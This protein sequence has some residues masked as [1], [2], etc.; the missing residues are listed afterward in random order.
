MHKVL[1]LIGGL[2]I[3]MA[4]VA[5]SDTNAVVPPPNLPTITLSESEFEGTSSSNEISSLLQSSRDIFVSTAGFNFG[6]FRYRMRGLDSENTHVL[7]N[8]VMMNDQ[9][10][11]RASYSSWGGLNDAMRNTEVN[12]MVEASDWAFGGIGGVTNILTRAGSYR[13]TT[14]LSYA[15]SNRS[16]NNRIMFL[17]STGMQDNGWAVT[18]SGSR[19]WSQEGYVPGTFYD[20]WSYFAS[21]EKKINN[22]HSFG[23]IAF[24]AP[25]K[26]A[27]SGVSVQEAY[28]L[29]GDNYYN[30][31]WGYQNG[32]VRNARVSNNNQPMFQ[33]S[34]YWTPSDKT[35]VQSTA[36]Y[37]FG[38]G[39]ATALDWTEANDP[40][41]DYYRNLP[42][43][44][45]SIG[46]F[47]NYEKYTNLWKNDEH[48]RQIKWDHFYF[49]NS[50]Q[51]TT[52]MNANGSGNPYT[53][54]KSKFVIEDRRMDK[55]Q[56]GLNINVQH[57]LNATAR[58]VGGL[59]AV[60][61]KTRHHKRMVDLLGGDFWLDIDKY[62]DQESMTIT[63]ASQ[64]DLRN[65]NHIIK[66]G[67][68]YGYDYLANVNNARLWSQFEYKFMKMEVYAAA[69]L[70][71]TQFWRTGKMQNGR[72]PNNSY[73]DG[74]K[75]NFLNGGA[76]AGIT[77]AIDGRNYVVANGAYLHRAP[78]FRDSYISPR[79]RD[80]AVEGLTSEKVLA[81]DISY[82]LRS[83]NLK[84]RLT[85]YHT[86]VHDGL[87]VRSY[88]HEDL[89]NFINYIMED[90]DQKTQGVELG[91]EANL[92][93]TLSAHAV[94]GKS[95]NIYTNRPVVT[96]SADNDAK[97]LAENRL[98]YLKNYYVG[99]APQTIASA[100]LRY[101]AP[102]YWFAGITA[103]YF[104]DA[105]LEPNPDNH[106]EEILS[107]YKEGDVR[108]DM[109]LDQPKL[110]PGFTLDF[111][112]GKSWMIKGHYVAINL[113]INNLLNNK[114][115]VIWGFEQLRTDLNDPN[116]FPEKYSYGY[117]T[118]Y[119]LSLT[120]RM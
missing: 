100:G 74:Q 63:D 75:F 112:G 118:T 19:R 23:L 42:S 80:F 96:I 29:T 47:T 119:F 64:N 35:K 43:Y 49:A 51:L 14:N 99:G 18:L 27:Y 20:A 111:F 11:G 104:A 76:K 101:N 60:S 38:R 94:F 25:T 58:L 4:G 117:G 3:A 22:R 9:E 108:I 36:Y 39:G 7:I 106:T 113:S 71:M 73:G 88:Y 68:V 116:R 52:I 53:G 69:E 1:L 95:M 78:N 61:S 91:L 8:G 87:W 86:Q 110:D 46:D 67:D 33:L 31:N 107:N 55:N 21:V 92:S 16:Y 17:Y 114:D 81:G 15:L 12:N 70:N 97:L 84:G 28:D 40:R 77:Y 2:L 56:L 79:T 30:A 105:Y 13:K 90:V 115:L 85:L 24:A 109:I 6:S 72:F 48:F 120:V 26:R 93:P 62:A 59:M 10:T 50:D 44:F 98:V 89:R 37:W 65:P 5:Q 54:H 102:K 66:E 41:P 32:K 57:Q 83:P 34:H 82:V 45:L 103:N